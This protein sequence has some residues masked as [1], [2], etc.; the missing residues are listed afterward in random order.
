MS[1]RRAPGPLDGGLVVDKPAGP[2]SH[3]VVAVVRR[4]LAQPRIGHT[5]T[6]DPLAT[7]VL[8]LLLG[9]ATRLARFL[10]ARE[11]TYLATVEFGQ[12]TT[13]RDAAGEPVGPATDVRLDPQGLEAALEAFRGRQQQVPPAVSAKRIGGAR[14]YALARR[15]LPVSLAPVEVEVISLELVSCA[16]SRAQLRVTASA[17]FYVRSL[18]HDLGARLGVGAHLAALRRERSGAFTL[19]DAVPLDQVVERPE[20]AAARVIPLAGLLPEAPAVVLGP[21]DVARVAHGQAVSAPPPGTADGKGNRV[22][23]LDADGRL[24]AVA[25]PRAGFLHPVVVLV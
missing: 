16:G 14:A 20:A 11:K 21:E 24:L 22:R 23:L 7:G 6:L 15:E 19:A 2:T 10:S 17:G 12:A 9:R 18:A 4:A 8:P 13:T 5:G 25:A 3:D 1:R